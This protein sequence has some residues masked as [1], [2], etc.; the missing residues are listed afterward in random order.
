[1]TRRGAPTPA[2]S[3]ALRSRAVEIVTGRAVSAAELGR[4]LGISRQAAGAILAELR[5]LGIAAPAVI[6]GASRRRMSR[7]RAPG[8]PVKLSPAL[9]A[10]LARW[11]GATPQEQIAA[12]LDVA[13]GRTDGG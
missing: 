12:V 4:E 9:L 6:A 3:A 10:R 2:E 8:R 13:E 5:R 7:P 1:M 11:P